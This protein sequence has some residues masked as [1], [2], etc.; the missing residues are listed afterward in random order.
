MFTPDCQVFDFDAQD[1][2]RLPDLFRQ[3]PPTK[4]PGGRAGGGIIAVREGQRI[5]KVTSTLRGRLPPPA[6]GPVRAEAL[7]SAHDG[8]FAV[9]LSR[10]ALEQF[11]DRFAQRLARGQSFHAQV[12]AFVDAMRE[13]E[14]EGEV[15]LWPTPFAQWPI[16]TE[17]AFASALDLLCP[18]GKSVVIGAFD[19]GQLYTALCLRRRGAAFDAVMGPD[20]VRRDMGLLSGDFSRDYRYLG[21]AVE[22]RLGP[23]A[24]GCYGELSTFRQL[25]MDPAP[26]AWASAVAG[27]DIVLTPVTVGLAV[28]LGVDAGRAALSLAKGLVSRLGIFGGMAAPSAFGLG[29]RIE[30]AYAL[31]EGDVRRYLGFDPWRVLSHWFRVQP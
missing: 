27:R 10:V 19:E 28:P 8:S 1:W 14:R 18:D 15:E 21:A 30:R 13:L 17:R 4:A 11:G 6:E 31:V 26:G 20:R 9:V 23:L 7:A 25:A 12:E 5:V 2:F 3:P 24:V 22:S 16:P 29:A